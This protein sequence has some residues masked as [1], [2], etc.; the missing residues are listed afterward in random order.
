MYSLPESQYSLTYKVMPKR[1]VVSTE[2]V[3]K[4]YF[5]STETVAKRYFVS[6]ETVAKRYFVSTET[7]VSTK[8]NKKGILS[9]LKTYLK[10][11]FVN[12]EIVFGVSLQGYLGTPLSTHPGTTCFVPQKPSHRE[13]CLCV[14]LDIA[15]PVAGHAPSGDLE[16]GIRNLDLG[17]PRG[18]HGSLAT[19]PSDPVGGPWVTWLYLCCCSGPC[20]NLR[21]LYCDVEL[22]AGLKHYTRN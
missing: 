8:S 15:G 1:Y 16:S 17:S 4:R 10:R 3:P 12:T 11:Y 22:E 2:T 9:V 14:P 20:Q 19:N 13:M 7:F 5:V 6:T 18:T 21:S